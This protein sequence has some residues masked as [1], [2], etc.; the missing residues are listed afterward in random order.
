MLLERLPS[1]TLNEL[2]V[3]ARNAATLGKLKLP[4]SRAKLLLRNCRYS[5]PNLSECAPRRRLRVSAAT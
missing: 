4:V 1:V 3:P 2:A 5:P